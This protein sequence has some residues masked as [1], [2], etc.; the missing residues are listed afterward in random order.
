MNL[1]LLH[2]I[3][4][5]LAQLLLKII[6][7][8]FND[9]DVIGLFCRRPQR[10]CWCPWLPE[11]PI[12]IQGKV[13]LLQHPGEEKR[14]LKTGP[15]LQHGLEA[16]SCLIFY[17]KKFGID[18]NNPG[19]VELLQSPGTLLLYPGYQSV[20]LN[21]VVSQRKPEDP[22]NIVILDGTWA[23]AKSLYYHSPMLH[24]LPQVSSCNFKKGSTV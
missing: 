18:S 9:T 24:S 7:P 1:Y 10:V 5:T 17:G 16:G 14:N 4:V 8:N 20:P 23:Q 15:M 6:S 11:R 13:I 2:A 21:D 3:I 22:Y 12:K 19:L